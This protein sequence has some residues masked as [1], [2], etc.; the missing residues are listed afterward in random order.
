MLIAHPTHPTMAPRKHLPKTAEA[1]R[2]DGCN[3]VTDFFQRSRA[4]R[5]KKRGKLTDKIRENPD[6]VAAAGAVLVPP[7]DATYALHKSNCTWLPGL[8]DCC[9][10]IACTH[11]SFLGTSLLLRTSYPG[12]DMQMPFALYPLLD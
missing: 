7:V 2:T 4:G 11:P 6:A 5:P 1:A 8:V 3:L 9:V 10:A 12:C